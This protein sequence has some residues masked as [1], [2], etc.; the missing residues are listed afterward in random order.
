MKCNIC[1]S[2]ELKKNF[3]LEGKHEIWS[4][5]QCTA[6]FMEPQLN[7]AEITELYSE[8]YYKSWG[9]SGQQENE[10]SKQMKIATFLLRLKLI[11]NYVKEGKALDVGCATGF[12]LEAARDQGFDPYGIELSE[13]S[14]GIAKNKFGKEKIFNGTLEQNNFEAGSFSVI[15]MFDL[16]EHVRLPQVS[17]KK[18]AELLHPNGI[19]IITTPHKD[20]ISNK[21]MG[22]KWTHYKLEHFY[23]FNKRSLKILAENCN[24][25]MIYSE[26][27][28]KA[29]NL[30]YL[31]TQFNVYPHALLTPMVNLFCRI[32]PKAI[33]QHNFNISIGEITVILKKRSAENK[34]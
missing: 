6:E 10:T 30:A 3:V 17:L 34:K 26:H 1:G 15:S 20:S 16:I 27:S 19:L 21:I 13:Y 32:L 18:A 29:L 5:P 31:H 24:M 25:D 11:R 14:S 8:K 2:Q 28:K 7:D 23:Y 12:Y 22:K 9:I 4:C 33:L